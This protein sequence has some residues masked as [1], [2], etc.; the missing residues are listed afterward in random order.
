MGLAG[1]YANDTVIM[2]EEKA[3][4]KE[5]SQWFLV[6]R[7][8]AELKALDLAFMYEGISDL[9]RIKAWTDDRSNMLEAW[10]STAGPLE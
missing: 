4:G 7:S 1:R 3:D 5:P 9:P 2:D 8:D 10:G 6:A